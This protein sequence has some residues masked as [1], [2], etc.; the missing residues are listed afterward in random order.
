MKRSPFF[1]CHLYIALMLVY[2]IAN[3]PS[4]ASAADPEPVSRPKIGLALSGGGARGAAH[5]GVIRVLEEN[6]VPID[7]VAG[8]SMGAIVGGL[9]SIGIDPDGLEDVLTSIDWDDVFDD[10]P[11]RGDRS[12]RRKRDDDNY[13][14]KFKAGF[15]DGK[16]AGPAGLVQGQ[17]IDLELARLFLP[18]ASVEDFDNLTIPFRAVATDIANGD[19]VVIG[20]GNI[21]LAIRASMSIPAALAPAKVQGR[22]LVDGGIAN[23][24]PISVVREMGADII[25]AVDISTPL[26]EEEDWTLGSIAS[27][28]TGLLTRRNVEDQIATLSDTDILIVPDLGDVA[29]TDFNEAAQAIVPGRAAALD[30]LDAIR[31]LSLSDAD[32]QV[33]RTSLVPAEQQQVVIDRIRL[34]NNSRLSNAYIESRIVDTQVGQ[35]LDIPTLERDLGKIYGL[36]LFQNVRYG[37]VEEGDETVLRI[38]VDE[39][40]WGPGYLQFG[41]EYSSDVRGQNLINLGA[42]YTKTGLNPRGG[43]WRSALQ[44]GSELAAFTE[45]HQPF[46]SHSMFFVNPLVGYEER[47]VNIIQNSNIAASY[48]INET[49]ASLSAGREFGTWGEARVGIRYADG[50]AEREVGGPSFS[51]MA[52]IRGETF[53]RLSVDELDDFN[54]PRQGTRVMAEW[55]GSRTGLGAD[56]KFDQLSLGVTGAFTRKRNTL[57]GS[58]S[59][60]ATISGTAPLQNLFALG[61]FGQLS[62]LGKKEL[63]GQHAALGLLAYYRRLN[64]SRRLPIYAGMT[65]EAGNVWDNRS[66][67]SLSDTITAGSLFLAANTFIGP[68]YLAYGRAEDKSGAFYFFLGRPF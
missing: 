56:T 38:R 2:A 32:Y 51:D 57:L 23:N 34:E 8:T 49:L 27:Q 17:K 45:L 15:N 36:E 44:V 5:I 48:R 33:Y 20:S 60:D 53:V 58:A 21:A 9:Y 11:P 29:T 62:G 22:T 67:I 61:G 52:Y 26:G 66:D 31:R 55:V 30:Q 1:L 25:I 42:S 63:S 50:E 40:S 54:I 3:R 14:I 19:A 59:Y 18:V 39:R 46:G 16:V 47:L 41:F 6:N 65:L 7:Y 24:L 12:F 64:D 28:L 4:A 43:E 37:L 10:L 13:L 35:P 68:L